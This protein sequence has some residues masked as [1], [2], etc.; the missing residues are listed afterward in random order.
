MQT[1]PGN[2]YDLSEKLSLLKSVYFGHMLG[3]IYIEEGKLKLFRRKI[4]KASGNV[5]GL[6]DKHLDLR[7]SF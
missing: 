3:G 4:P 2:L 5:C 1:A 7:L 6:A